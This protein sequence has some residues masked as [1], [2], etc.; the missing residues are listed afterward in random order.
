VDNNGASA[1]AVVTLPIDVHVFER[2][3]QCYVFDVRNYAVLRVGREFARVLGLASTHPV[4]AIVDLLA[5]DVSADVVAQHYVRILDLIDE[6]VLSSQPVPRP[7]RPPFTHLVVMLAGGCNMGCTYCFERDVPIYQNPN[8]M[9]VERADE[10]LDWFFRHQEGATAHIQLYGGEP[11]LNWKVLRH[12]VER[13]EAWAT[14]HGKTL[15]KYLITNGTLLRPERI[16][17]LREHDVTVQVSVDGDE[18]THDRF[19]IFKTGKPTLGAI[20]PNVAELI[21]QGADFNLRAVMTRANKDPHAVTNGLKRLGGEKVSFEVVATEGDDVA[22][23]DGDWA[24]FNETY[25]GYVHAPFAT[26]QE[27]PDE[28]KNMIVR[29]CEHQRVFYGCGA[30]VSEVTVAPDGSIYECQRIYRTP[31][32]NVSED[33]SPTELGSTL[34]TMVDDRPICQDCWARYLCGGGCMHQS[35]V[36]HGSDDPLPQYCEMKRTLVESAVIRIDEIRRVAARQEV[37]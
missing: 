18:A 16:T 33:R 27:L 7:A 15:T 23:D 31:Y 10:V 34:Q 13:S 29:I 4:D 2:D 36:G 19:R 32:S 26:W 17:F 24:E 20:K 1:T 25:D 21:E 14:D 11:L 9:T 22:F 8:L 5:D 35:H 3:G 37:S 28:L 6:G 30:G 12:V